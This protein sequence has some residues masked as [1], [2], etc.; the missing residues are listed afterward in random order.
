MKKD[1]NVVNIF[2]S[3]FLVYMCLEYL[4]VLG[5][6]SIELHLVLLT[7][8]AIYYLIFRTFKKCYISMDDV[9]GWLIMSVISAGVFYAIYHFGYAVSCSTMF[10]ING[11]RD[12]TF[13]LSNFA[14]FG[15]MLVINIFSFFSRT[16]FLKKRKTR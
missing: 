8:T 2:G 9:I 11:Y 3:F 4:L 14:F 10:C 6:L 5:D 15:I 7:M 12:L 1:S 16:L 13:V